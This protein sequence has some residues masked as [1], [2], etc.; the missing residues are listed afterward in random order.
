MGNFLKKID[1]FEIP[2]SFRYK[3]EDGFSTVIGGIFTLAIIIWFIIILIYDFIP[4]I[5]KENFTFFF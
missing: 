5:K 3:K 4:F 1:L 2:I